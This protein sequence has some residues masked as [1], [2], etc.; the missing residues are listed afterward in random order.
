MARASVATEPRIILEQVAALAPGPAP[1]PWARLNR[2]LRTPRIFSLLRELLE[3]PLG[4]H[5]RRLGGT[6]IP[7]LAEEIRGRMLLC[8]SA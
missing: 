4:R 2:L 7:R 6:P 3:K 1:L 5:V 8:A